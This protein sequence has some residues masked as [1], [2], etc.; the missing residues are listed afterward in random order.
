MITETEQDC[1]L[2]IHLYNSYIV[3]FKFFVEKNIAKRN[4]EKQS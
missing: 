3:L 1:K 4:K 2:D